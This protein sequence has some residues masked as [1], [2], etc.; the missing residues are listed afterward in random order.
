MAADTNPYYEVAI[1]RYVKVDCN[2]LPLSRALKQSDKRIKYDN[3]NQP[4]ALYFKYKGTSSEKKMLTSLNLSENE[5]G[6]HPLAA[7]HFDNQLCMYFRGFK[8]LVTFSPN[9]P[10]ALL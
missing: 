1:S 2:T 9:F 7:Q 4:S 10:A 3:K 6:E 8:V 5:L